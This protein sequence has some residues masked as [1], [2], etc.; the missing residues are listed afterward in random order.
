MRD[1]GGA[2]V[3]IGSIAAQLSDSGNSL[4][5]A[6]K[7]A[8]H[9]L[10]RTADLTKEVVVSVLS[11]QTRGAVGDV[12]TTHSHVE[13]VLSTRDRA[14]GSLHNPANFPVPDGQD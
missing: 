11:W 13:T 12:Q 10:T 4:Y 5:N 6:S 8:A 2:I 1:N 7:S 9:S 3:N 14:S